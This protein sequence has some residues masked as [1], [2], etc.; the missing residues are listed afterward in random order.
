MPFLIIMSIARNPYTHD[1]TT[2]SLRNVTFKNI[3]VTTPDGRIPI[4]DIG[5]DVEGS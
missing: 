5:S 2:G 1:S 3:S 4:C